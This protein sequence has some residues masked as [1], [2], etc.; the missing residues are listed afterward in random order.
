MKIG[1]VT[2]KIL[3]AIYPGAPIKSATFW[4][5]LLFMPWCT[6]KLENI[7]HRFVQNCTEHLLKKSL[8]RYLQKWKSYV[9]NTEIVICPSVAVW[10]YDFLE[11]FTFHVLKIHC[12]CKWENKL[13]RFVENFI[14]HLFKKKIQADRIKIER[15]VSKTKKYF[16]SWSTR[17]N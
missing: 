14:A 3:I 9:Q 15:T 13:D 17:Y 4:K 8:A 6:R 12:T 10:K 11:G 16:F 2:T 5:Y 1:K 7:L